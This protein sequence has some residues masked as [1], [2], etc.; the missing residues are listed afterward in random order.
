MLKALK[1]GLNRIYI[2]IYRQ[3]VDNTLKR[4]I[5]TGSF[6]DHQRSGH[7][8]LLDNAHYVAVE[9]AIDSNNEI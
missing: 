8:R 5:E 3:T 9:N 4:Y 1:Y 2:Y 6:V 7:L